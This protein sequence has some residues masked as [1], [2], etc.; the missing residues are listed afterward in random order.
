MIYKIFRADEWA[1]LQT[2]GVT[3]GAPIDLIDGFIH[4]S[5]ATQAAQTAALHFAGATDLRL[6]AVDENRLDP[7]LKWEKSRGGADFPH[8][9]RALTMEDVVWCVDLPLTADGHVFPKDLT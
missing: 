6:A 1:H 4:F 9:Y 3:H 2:Q 7:D 5:T 8:L